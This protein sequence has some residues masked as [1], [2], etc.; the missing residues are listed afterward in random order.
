MHM[1]EK[2]SFSISLGLVHKWVKD[3]A[4]STGGAQ[5]QLCGHSLASVSDV[6]RTPPR[7][8]W[9][10]YDSQLAWERLTVPLDELE[11]MTGAR[12]VR[13]SAETVAP[14]TQL[15]IFAVCTIIINFVTTQ[16]AKKGETS[17][18]RHCATCFGRNI[19]CCCEVIVPMTVKSH[20]LPV[21]EWT[22]NHETTGICH[23][24]CC[25]SLLSCYSTK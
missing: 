1:L 22:L 6:S 9:R 17:P 7:T 23:W 11:E 19:E 4:R 20:K 24:L 21:S 8:R 3:K 5:L 13:V 25:L 16:Q 18:L 14:T 15:Q 12:K 10:D 2:K